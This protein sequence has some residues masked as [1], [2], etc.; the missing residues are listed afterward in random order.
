MRGGSL[1]QSSGTNFPLAVSP[2]TSERGRTA[3]P[4]R[5]WL[6]GS[7]PLIGAPSIADSR[8]PVIPL[9]ITQRSLRQAAPPRPIVEL[10]RNRLRDIA[11]P[12]TMDEAVETPS[13]Y[14]PRRRSGSRGG[15][16]SQLSINA[17]LRCAIGGV[18]GVRQD[19]TFTRGRKADLQAE[20]FD[21]SPI[22][23]ESGVRLEAG[24]RWSGERGL[25]SR[26]M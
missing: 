17:V 18:L 6:T 8:Q 9:T 11:F 15:G 21:G 24:L 25:R 19:R 5:H 4:A 14:G 10:W 7:A 20:C 13:D 23:W 16:G 1:R 3:D 22:G 12:C 26:T 2:V